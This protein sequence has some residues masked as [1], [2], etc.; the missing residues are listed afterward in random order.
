MYEAFGT[1]LGGLMSVAAQAVEVSL[2][3]GPGVAIQ[4]VLTTYTHTVADDRRSASIRLADMLN[5]ENRDLLL[6]LTLPAL[7]APAGVW[8]AAG[9]GGAAQIGGIWGAPNGVTVL[10]A[11]VTYRE[12]KT[13]TP[14]AASCQLRVARPPA[15]D[16]SPDVCP[17]EDVLAQ[18]HRVSTAAAIREVYTLPPLTSR[19]WFQLW[20]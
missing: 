18:W 19:S 10:T 14:R 9:D 13:D 4:D 17:N 11:R 2:E 1:V 5:G 3:V 12:A 16:I 6:R 8:G 20:F 15:Q 7:E